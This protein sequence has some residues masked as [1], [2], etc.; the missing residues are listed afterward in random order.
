[1]DIETRRRQFI[2]A[3]RDAEQRYGI[4]VSAQVQARMENGRV[5][6]E[7]GPVIVIPIEGWQPAGRGELP[8]SE[9]H[10]ELAKP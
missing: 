6:V 9:N 3:L 2:Q 8:S 7:P 5:I 10:K 1:M 4:T